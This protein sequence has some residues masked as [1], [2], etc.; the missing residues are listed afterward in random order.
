L[1]EVRALFLVTYFSAYDDADNYMWF[2]TESEA[3][4][5]I[6]LCEELGNKVHD[7]MEIKDFRRL[8]K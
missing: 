6:E 2:R 1:K 8:D 4:G 5:F 7:A 3:I